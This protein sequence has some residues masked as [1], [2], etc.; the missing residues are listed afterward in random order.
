VARRAQG[1]E[2]SND[3]P[4]VS[5]IAA[6]VLVHQTRTNA[7]SAHSTR[8]QS[9]LNSLLLRSNEVHEIYPKRAFEQLLGQYWFASACR[10]LGA[11]RPAVTR[12]I[13]SPLA[14]CVDLGIGFDWSDTR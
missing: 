8:R 3:Y 12:F 9:V 11:G 6:Y 10:N 4:L 13:N 5:S 14:R 1:R 2:I 7:S